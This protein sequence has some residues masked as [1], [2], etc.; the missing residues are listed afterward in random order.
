MIPVKRSS[1]IWRPEVALSIDRGSDLNRRI[2][3][4]LPLN[5]SPFE[6]VSGRQL[7]LGSGGSF[8]NDPKGRVLNGTGSASCASIPLDLSAY[9]RLSISFWLYWNAYANDDDFAME[10]TANANSNQ[11]FYIDP[12]GSGG[13]FTI[14]V[15]CGGGTGVAEGWLPSRPSAAAWHHYAINM[16]HSTPS[17][18]ATAIPNV[19]VDG[20]PVTV[21]AAAYTGT[22][23]ANA[24]ANSTL[25]LFSR[26]GT[27]LFGAG[28]LANLVI[29]GGSL[30]TTQDVQKEYLDPWSLYE[31]SR[32]WVPVSAGGGADVTLALSGQAVTASAGT[33]T[34]TASL[35]LSGQ[36][37]TASAGT[38]TSSQALSGQ[39]VTASAGI[40][41]PTLTITLSGQAVTAS[42]G[43]ITYNASGDISVAL[44][45]QAVTASAGTLTPTASPALSG[46]A[47]T[48][49]A[50]TVAPGISKAATGEQITTSAGTLTLGIVVPASG[51]GVTCSAGTVTYSTAGDVTVALSGQAVTVSAGTLTPLGAFRAGNPRAWI[52]DSR[53]RYVHVDDSPSSWRV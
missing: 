4:A 3:W 46:Q 9:T 29:R 40:A 11:G 6:L 2:T 8:V 42:A 16:V 48:A 45:G 35:A 21:S 10:F 36:A 5:G 1:D 15:S 47:V 22:G 12:N 31:Q 38:L 33:L 32:I 13:S 24:F 43:T 17:T 37:V 52:V 50:S 51:Q 30:L 49:S 34:P 44:S 39:A 23:A 19:W 18:V 27:S 41:T 25:Y 14:D 20:A 7:T 53:Q 26:A 28:R